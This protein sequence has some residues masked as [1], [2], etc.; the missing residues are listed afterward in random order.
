MFDCNF[1]QK[2]VDKFTE[3]SK[4]VFFAIFYLKKSKCG[5]WV[6]AIKSK[7]FRDFLEIS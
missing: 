1:R 5:F 4:I 3:S 2:Y 7:H 6:L